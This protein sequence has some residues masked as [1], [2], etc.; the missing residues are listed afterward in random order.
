[1]CTVIYVYKMVNAGGYW[2]WFLNLSTCN[3]YVLVLQGK[4]NT[5]RSVH[6]LTKSAPVT[7]GCNMQTWISQVTLVLSSSY[8][9][10]TRLTLVTLRLCI[11]GLICKVAIYRFINFKT[12]YLSAQWFDFDDLYINIIRGA[13]GFG[14]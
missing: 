8:V 4:R 13:S 9:G 10:A 11:D 1:M 7:V 2:T 5:P 3:S 12:S 6:V 14:V